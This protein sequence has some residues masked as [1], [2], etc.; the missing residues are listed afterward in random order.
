MTTDELIMDALLDLDEAMLEAQFPEEEVFAYEYYAKRMS[1]ILGI[2]PEE[3]MR[4]KICTS[5]FRDGEET[6]EEF[7]DRGMRGITDW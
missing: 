1:E 3:V 7:Q 2:S 6:W 5:G 4:D